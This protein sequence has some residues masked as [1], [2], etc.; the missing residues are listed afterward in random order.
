[1]IHMRTDTVVETPT[2]SEPLEAR[3]M[4][5]ERPVTQASEAAAAPAVADPPASRAGRRWWLWLLAAAAALLVVYLLLPKHG[6]ARAQGAGTGSSGG[7]NGKAG[8]P[9]SRA[10]PVG[11]VAAKKKDVGVFLTGLGTVAPLATV[12]VKSRVD[13]QLVTLRFHDGQLVRAG[14]V[15]ADIDPRPFQV[16]LMQAQGQRAKDEAA[17]QNARVDLQRYQVLAREDSIPRQQLD[18]Q[19]ASVRQIEATLESDQAQIESA[20]LNLSYCRIAAPLSGRVGLRLVDPG[21]MVH[22]SD[23]NGLVVITQ[24]QPINVVFTLPADQLPAVLGPVHAGRQLPVDALDRELKRRLASGALLAVDNQIDPATGTVRLKASFAN[25]DEALFPNQFV[26]A[27][28][29]VNTLHGATV[30]PTAA[31]QRSPQSTFVYVVKPDKAVEARNVQVELTQGEE[32]VERGVAAGEV[33]VVDG[34]DKLRPGMKVEVSRA[35]LAGNGRRGGESGSAP[36]RTA[37]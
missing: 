26:N 31:V 22:A 35:D 34:L 17:L 3:T 25:G 16:Q 23:P 33:V 5:P 36:Q 11:A 7:Q 30:I 19:A 6:G 32:T 27:R 28:L 18:T 24:L 15:L 13:G 1:M 2:P 12:T 29:L 14:E 8:D 21:N 9:A 4:T 20:K 10:V 37:L